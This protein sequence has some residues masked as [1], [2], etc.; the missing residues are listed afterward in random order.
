MTEDTKTIV[1]VITEKSEKCSPPE[2]TKEWRRLA[3]KIMDQTMS[4][5]DVT[6]D[7]FHVGDVVEVEYVVKDNYKN[8]TSMKKSEAIPPT[9]AATPVP[10]VPEP[11]TQ[12]PLAAPEKIHLYVPKSDNTEASIVSQ[13]L[14]K[15]LTELV[16][17][18]KI[19]PGS[20]K[21]NAEILIKIYK[22]TKKSLL[23]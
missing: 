18:G 4:T 3:F 16:C 11:A 5:F 21:V 12:I 23:E 8:I 7:V 10:P 19:E 22:E 1:G 9:T 2:A 14:I 17:A 20:M 13:V 6:H 15:S